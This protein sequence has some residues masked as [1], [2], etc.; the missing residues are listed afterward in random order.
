[1]ESGVWRREQCNRIRGDDAGSY[2]AG[3]DRP[4]PG[5]KL[6]VSASTYESERTGIHTVELN[7]LVCIPSI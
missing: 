4:L 6:C 7:T 1:M 5:T 3:R 2:R